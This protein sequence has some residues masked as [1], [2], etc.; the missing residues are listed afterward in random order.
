MNRSLYFVR[1]YLCFFL[2]SD[3]IC[4]D[5]KR[6]MIQ[7]CELLLRRKSS[8]NNWCD[9]FNS[10]LGRL[11][12]RFSHIVCMAS[13]IQT[14]SQVMYNAMEI[15]STVFT[16]SLKQTQGGPIELLILCSLSYW[17]LL[18]CNLLLSLLTAMFCCHL[19]RQSIQLFIKQQMTI[20]SCEIEFLQKT[21][22]NV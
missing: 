22:I 3:S 11:N 15:Q 5:T 8:N 2:Y 14:L 4:T 1:V 12:E 19:K 16:C 17:R 20:S 9:E 13:F 10:C 18:R 21:K 7:M 6:T